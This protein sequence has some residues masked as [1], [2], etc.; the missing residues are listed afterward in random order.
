MDVEMIKDEKG[1][2]IFEFLM[3]VPFLIILFATLVKIQGALNSSINQQKAARGYYFNLLRHNSMLP[4]KNEVA[5]M[6]TRAGIQNYGLSLLGWRDYSAGAGDDESS[7]NPVAAC[8]NLIGIS[9]NNESNDE[10]EDPI[11]QDKTRV[12]NIRVYTAF[13]LCSANYSLNGNDIAYNPRFATTSG[14]C[15]NQ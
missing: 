3:F 12:K 4:D 1:Q 14:A 8:F 11:P 5:G 10:C 7:V 2:S 6:M 15:Q 9:T 13:G